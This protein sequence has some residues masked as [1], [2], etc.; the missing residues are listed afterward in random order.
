MTNDKT[1]DV[2]KKMVKWGFIS[3][4]AGVFILFTLVVVV[5]IVTIL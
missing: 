2:A 5:I 1:K 4:G 3:I